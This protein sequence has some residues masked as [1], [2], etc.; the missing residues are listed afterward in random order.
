MDLSTSLRVPIVFLSYSIRAIGEFISYGAVSS[1][2]RETQMNLY[3]EDSGIAHKKLQTAKFIVKQ[4]SKY[5]IE[6]IKMFIKKDN[7]QREAVEFE[8]L[9][10]KIDYAEDEDVLR[11]IE[12]SI[13][14]LYFTF[15][16]Q[17]LLN[18]TFEKRSRQ[19]PKNPPNAV[20]S[21]MNMT[22]YNRC[23]NEVIRCL[24][25]PWFGCLHEMQFGRAS[26][27]ID[28][29]ELYRPIL[30]DL[31]IFRLFRQKILNG[32]HFTVNNDQCLIKETGK[33]RILEHLQYIFDCQVFVEDN[34]TPISFEN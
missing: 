31:A 12:G 8:N 23:E 7:W 29:A 33:Q 20:L 15:W 5:R 19:P 34:A 27:G 2:E 25:D 4:A 18:E 21:Y 13:M 30:V 22:L 11:G 3:I 16:D 10:S 14:N 32:S 6:I 17:L 24:L 1:T 28:I 9:M 26:L